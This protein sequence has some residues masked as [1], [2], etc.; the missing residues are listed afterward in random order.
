MTSSYDF[1]VHTSRSDGKY[2]ARDILKLV[3]EYGIKKLSITDH[4]TFQGYREAIR[5]ADSYG[6]EL[7]SGIEVSTS[8]C[9]QN[10]FVEEVH[11]L[12]YG[13]VP[14][15]LEITAYENELMELQND[16]VAEILM[17]LDAIG[18]KLDFNTLLKMAAPAPISVLPI[19]TLLV[20]QGYLQLNLNQIRNFVLTNFIP[21]GPAYVPP[22]PTFETTLDKVIELGGIVVFAHPNKVET[23]RVRD[24]LF[25]KAHGIEVFYLQHSK[26]ETDLMI[27]KAVV[28]DKLMSVGSDFHGYYESE[29]KSVK[30]TQSEESLI[31]PFVERL[32]SYKYR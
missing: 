25:N 18:Y 4:D 1:H 31:M 17:K 30:L 6:I 7:F 11:I 29:Y 26:S 28:N 8:F 15:D 10:E 3:C 23:E 19:V 12:V 13:L 24:M 22:R 9:V 2:S 5:I 16:R 14:E 27:Q 32:R 20:M 21:G